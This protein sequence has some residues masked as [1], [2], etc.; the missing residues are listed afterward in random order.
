MDD[1]AYVREFEKLADRLGIEI[2]RIAEG[3]SGLCKVRERR[4][5]FLERGIGSAA[6]C[7]VFAREFRGFD[8]EGVYLVPA[9]R[10][11]L[12]TRDGANG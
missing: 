10:E 8:L 4:V 5:L 9:I 7:A 1:A 6:E 3:P 2:R 11:L 12:E